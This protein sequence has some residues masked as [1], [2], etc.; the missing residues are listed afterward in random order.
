MSIDPLNAVWVCVRACVRVCVK[1]GAQKFIL[2]TSPPTFTPLKSF[3]RQRFAQLSEP[4][5][6]E[7]TFPF[8]S[9]RDGTLYWYIAYCFKTIILVYHL[10]WYIFLRLYWCIVVRLYWC[11]ILR[12]YWC[13]VLRLYWCIVLRLY[14]CIILRLYWYIV[15]RLYWCVVLWLLVYQYK[16]K[17]Y[18]YCDMSM[19]CGFLMADNWIIWLG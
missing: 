2:Y 10:Y 6:V 11:I 17:P 15:L 13:I 8:V 19:Y 4:S 12:L 3:P 18:Q 9:T 7:V 5:C 16:V 1:L 14:W